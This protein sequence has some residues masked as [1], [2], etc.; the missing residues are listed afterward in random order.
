MSLAIFDLD[1]TLIAGDSDHSWGEFLVAQSIVDR[2]LYKEMNDKFYAD[3]ESGNL[4]IFAYLE[5]SVEPLTRLPMKDL[6][7]LHKLFMQDIVKPMMLNQATDLIHRHR[8]AGDRLLVITSTNRF[9]VEPICLSLGIDE[10]I[11]T[12]LEIVNGQYSGNIVGTPTFQEGKV[13][14]FN[15]WLEENNESNSDS[16]FYSDS[17]NDL[18]LLMEVAHP[19]AVDPDSALRKEAESRQWKIISLRD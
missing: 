10:I 5:F 13:V 17:I 15:Q 11:A 9:I 1:N 8:K 14:R 19:V 12:D 4:D 3:Y 2:Q 6:Q 16:Y 18:P 7:Q